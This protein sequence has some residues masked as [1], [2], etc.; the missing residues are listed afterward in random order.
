MIFKKFYRHFFQYSQNQLIPRES[1]LDHTF[2]RPIKTYPRNRTP[3]QI[4]P[5]N[6]HVPLLMPLATAT[7][8]RKLD[9][10]H[11]LPVLHLL[12]T[13]LCPL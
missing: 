10:T 6:Q 9:R 3:M 12:S 11:F 5:P 1:D 13:L 2:Q 4:T 7:A 8:A